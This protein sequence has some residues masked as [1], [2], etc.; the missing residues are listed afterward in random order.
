[1]AK[2]QIALPKPAEVIPLRR[3]ANDHEPLQGSAQNEERP[4]SFDPSLTSE[5]T[6]VPGALAMS[7]KSPANLVAQMVETPGVEPGRTLSRKY[8]SQFGN[9]RKCQ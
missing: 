2:L 3:A 7:A 4:E 1:V 9:R 8:A 5:L 6:S